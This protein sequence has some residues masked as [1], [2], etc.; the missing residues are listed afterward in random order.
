MS[1]LHNENPPPPPA[2]SRRRRRVI[3]VSFVSFPLLSYSFTLSR[4][5]NSI[6]LH[7]TTNKNQ[8]SILPSPSSILLLHPP[9]S[10]PFFSSPSTPHHNHTDTRAPN[11]EHGNPL[12]IKSSSRFFYQPRDG[13]IETERERD[14]NEWELSLNWI[15]DSLPFSIHEPTPLFLVLLLFVM[16]FLLSI[17]VG[18]F[19]FDQLKKG[20]TNLNFGFDF[21]LQSCRIKKEKE[22]QEEYWNLVEKQ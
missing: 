16:T 1:G 4:T 2:R 3:P 10:F 20:P 22:T 14:W 9:S 17:Q 21:S 18:P 15:V 13:Q 7:K 12:T 6:H 5:I 19:L 8:P 11:G